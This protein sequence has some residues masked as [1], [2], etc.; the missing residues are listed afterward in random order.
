MAW[1]IHLSKHW[2]ANQPIIAHAILTWPC[3]RMCTELGWQW[4]GLRVQRAL[5]RARSSRQKGRRRSRRCLHPT[6][7][8]LAGEGPAAAARPAAARQRRA[9][10]RGCSVAE[11]RAPQQGC[12]GV[13]C[14][15]AAGAWL[16]L[17]LGTLMLVRRQRQLL[18]EVAGQQL[19]RHQAARPLA[20][21]QQQVLHPQP[22][23]QPPGAGL[24]VQGKRRRRKSRSRHRWNEGEQGGGVLWARN[25]PLA[26]PQTWAR[27]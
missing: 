21:R 3:R 7:A 13:L 16:L 23:R 18:P 9:R 25:L 26:P 22:R 20:P 27:Q 12:A 17:R 24:L 6:L 11:A 5:A 4:P 15:A 8:A 19:P 14:G 10:E 1:L 2:T